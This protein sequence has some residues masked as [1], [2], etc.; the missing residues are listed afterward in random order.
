MAGLWYPGIRFIAPPSDR[1]ERYMDEVKKQVRDLTGIPKPRIHWVGWSNGWQ[2]VGQG[3]TG[4]GETPARA[5]ERWRHNATKP[6]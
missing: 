6:T 5:Y 1:L 4:L 3:A 2:C